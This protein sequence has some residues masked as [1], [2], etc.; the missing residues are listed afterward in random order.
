MPRPT[1]HTELSYSARHTDTITDVIVAPLYVVTYNDRPIGLRLRYQSRDGAHY[2]RTAYNSFG[3][4]ERCA[5]RLN[6]KFKTDAFCVRE[7]A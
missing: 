2:R 6:L 5:R 4:A 7:V 1:L 3:Q